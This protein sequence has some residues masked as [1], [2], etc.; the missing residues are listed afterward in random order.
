MARCT[1]C[2]RDVLK[3]G[4]EQICPRCGARVQGF[5]VFKN[6]IPF[7]GILG[8]VIAGVLGTAIHAISGTVW[9]G[10]WWFMIGLMIGGMIGKSRAAQVPALNKAEP[11]DESAISN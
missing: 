3:T 10:N 4:R 8:M 1:N 11:R 6:T 7:C 9:A 2:W 5:A